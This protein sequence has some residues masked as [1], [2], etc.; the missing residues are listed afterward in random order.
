MIV[1]CVI[2]ILAHWRAYYPY[3]LYLFNLLIFII[4]RHGITVACFR[5]INKSYNGVSAYSKAQFDDEAS[6]DD[7][8]ST[9]TRNHVEYM[10]T[11]LESSSIDYRFKSCRG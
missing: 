9:N 11:T 4:L 10:V 5:N 8:T 2:V 7:L 6:V 3:L 1:Y